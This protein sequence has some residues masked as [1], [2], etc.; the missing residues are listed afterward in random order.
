MSTKT[1]LDLD[2]PPAYDSPEASASSGRSYMGTLPV[3][4]VAV[5]ASNVCCAMLRSD[6]VVD[7]TVGRGRV[8]QQLEAEEGMT[9]TAVSNDMYALYLLR[10]DGVL[11]RHASQTFSRNA[12]STE[13]GPK[14]ER[15]PPGGQT[16]VG[17]SSG[18]SASYFLR[19]DGQVDRATTGGQV[20]STLQ[21]DG[22]PGVTYTEASAGMDLSFLL[23]SDGKVDVVR[24]GK[25]GK[26]YETA[27]GY[28][29][30]SQQVTNASDKSQWGPSWVY[31]LR[32]D[33]A[34]DRYPT[35]SVDQDPSE[36][37]PPVGQRYTYATAGCSQSY[38]LSP[39]GA[40]RI[41]SGKIKKQFLSPGLGSW[42][43]VQASCGQDASYLLRNDG[44]VE[45]VGG[46]GGKITATI[47]P[48]KLGETQG[49]GCVLQ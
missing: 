7:V 22:F 23:R 46:W 12:F 25:V 2:Q 49:A 3:G 31:F 36:M 39:T 8:N 44:F 18:P 20:T 34:A 14:N 45:R 6:G 43:Y 16:Y 9:Y 40:D 42:A 30:V 19:S 29:A 48:P 24:G 11:I 10:S 28:T 17:M 21:P 37:R 27:T 32:G 1:A 15:R 5:S 41:V 47:A 13:T 4:Y 38:L 26:T 33:G 35:R